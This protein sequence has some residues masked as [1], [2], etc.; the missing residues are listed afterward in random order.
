MTVNTTAVREGTSGRRGRREKF[1]EA[2]RNRQQRR[3]SSDLEIVRNLT[4]AGIPF[5]SLEFTETSRLA[6]GVQSFR[7][8]NRFLIAG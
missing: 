8:L 4:Q 7:T 6:G 3:L 5:I 2:S 1:G